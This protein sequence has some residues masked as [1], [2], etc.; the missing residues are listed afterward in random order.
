MARDAAF[1]A[2]V[3]AAADKYRP[4]GRNAYHFTRGKLSRDP[5]FFALLMQGLIP[6]NARV[7]DL[8]CGQGVLFA[9]LAA[10]EDPGLRQQWPRDRPP[11]PQGVRGA[12]VDLRRDA[13]KAAQT[14]LGSS[15][16]LQVGDIR[17]YVIP[18]SDVVTIFD[19]LHYIGPE[20]QRRV[21]E[22]VYLALKPGGLLLLRVGDADAGWRFKLTLAG[23]W[24]ITLLRGHW[25]RRF[26][27]RG[28]R[29]WVALLEE[30][31]FY[32][33]LQPMSEGTPFA[34]VLVVARKPENG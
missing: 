13:V 15:I 23:D 17:R 28:A 4:A 19:V 14:A 1:R 20:S 8:G 31:G 32:A 3:D 12:G 10:A 25:Q 9:L 27:A 33:A 22:R 18:P 34:N 2:L 30:I 29:E 11:L 21:L 5:V 6:D 16:A 24:F 7:T 26:F